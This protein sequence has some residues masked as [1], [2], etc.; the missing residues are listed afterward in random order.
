MFDAKPQWPESTPEKYVSQLQAAGLTIVDVQEW[1][2]HL[3]F[4]DLGAVVYYLK[5]VP[6][7]VPGFSVAT[8]AEQLLTLQRRLESGEN[9]AF[10]AKK[11]L[12]EAQKVYA[13]DFS[14]R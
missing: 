9:L 12:I 8:H 5:A 6:W 4:T 1:S 7:L 2:G 11:Y 14:D 3:S 13:Y 10:A